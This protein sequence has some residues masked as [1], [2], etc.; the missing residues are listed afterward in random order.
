VASSLP[1]VSIPV[2]NEPTRDA[3]PLVPLVRLALILITVIA[4]V[5]LLV[6][7]NR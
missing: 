1:A 5:K 4:V 3:G 7:S 2:C 6:R